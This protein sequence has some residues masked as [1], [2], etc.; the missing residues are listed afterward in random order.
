MNRFVLSALLLLGGTTGASAEELPLSADECAVW[1]R[2]LSFAHSVD[3][4]DAAAFASHIH[5]QAVFEAAT[6]SPTRGRDA[7]VEAWAP[8]LED[9]D[10]VLVWRPHFVS[11]GGDPNVAMSRGPVM[12]TDNRT[13]TKARYRIN[14]FASVWV[15]KNAKSP[16]LVLFDGGGP[17]STPVA[18]EAEALAYLAEAPATCP[19]K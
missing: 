5:P 17:P 15:R 13:E 8:L 1:N 11:I 19:M 7:V 9:K 2:E 18:T 3:S 12:I 16:W 14:T 10:V 4:H 6:A